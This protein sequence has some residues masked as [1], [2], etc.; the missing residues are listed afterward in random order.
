MCS[1]SFGVCCT[2]CLRLNHKLHYLITN[3]SH[4]ETNFNF[5]HKFRRAHVFVYCDFIITA[6][7]VLVNS[8]WKLLKIL[9]K[10]FVWNYED[11]DNINKINRNLLT[12]KH[13]F[14]E[15]SFEHIFIQWTCSSSCV[16]IGITTGQTFNQKRSLI[17][18]EENLNSY[19][20]RKIR[21]TM[22]SFMTSCE[23]NLQY[24]IEWHLVSS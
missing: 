16:L 13:N 2:S 15:L 12:E 22:T 23:T 9:G 7:Q 5:L 8:Y 11:I 21:H 20:N 18:I 4:T 3:I 14:F 1:Y 24:V 6:K 10:M 17:K 19:W